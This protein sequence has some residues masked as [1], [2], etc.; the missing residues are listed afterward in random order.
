MSL[1]NHDK[2]APKVPYRA[3]TYTIINGQSDIPLLQSIFGD[4]L[5]GILGFN[6]KMVDLTIGF[7]TDITIKLNSGY[8]DNFL[9][10]NASGATAYIN[11]AD[12]YGS[13]PIDISEIYISNSS[14][15]SAVLDVLILAHN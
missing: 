12:L 4:K 9:L 7:N 1:I 10:R 5:P 14:G 13:A 15:S 6:Q 11:F 8:N 3:G 2:S